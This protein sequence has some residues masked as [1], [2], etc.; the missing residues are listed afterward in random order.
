MITVS[1]VSVQFGKRVLFND[2][3]L[4]LPVV[5]ATALSVPTVPENQLFYV[6]FT[7]IWTQ[8]REQSRKVRANVCPF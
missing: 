5:T 6:L 2:V 3:T 8:Q 1:N 7:V 4:N